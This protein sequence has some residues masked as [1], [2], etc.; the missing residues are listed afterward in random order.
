MVFKP[1]L[2]DQSPSF[3]V[4][5]VIN[6]MKIQTLLKGWSFVSLLYWQSCMLRILCNYSE[7]IVNIRNEQ[8]FSTDEE[9]DAYYSLNNSNVS[10]LL[11]IF[12][13]LFF[14]TFW[15]MPLLNLIPAMPSHVFHPPRS[16]VPPFPFR[17][18]EHK[19]LIIC[20]KTL[21]LSLPHLIQIFVHIFNGNFILS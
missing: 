13:L 3:G 1:S 16:T 12:S 9:N 15:P 6:L 21:N 10:F 17:K 19:V 20:Y 4:D 18:E 8:Q 2:T 7:G 14:H 11:N 5:M